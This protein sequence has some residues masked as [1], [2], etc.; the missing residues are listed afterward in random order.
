[1]ERAKQRK[2]VTQLTHFQTRIS[3]LPSSVCLKLTA[4][5][6]SE[7]KCE[8]RYKNTQ[9]F[10]KCLTNSQQILQCSCENFL[11]K[12]SFRINLHY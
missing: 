4:K 7:N 11:Y 5:H 2:Y 12:N 1:M 3:L 10:R 8:L 6:V 9:F